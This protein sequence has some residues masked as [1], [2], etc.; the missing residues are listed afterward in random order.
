MSFD[1][2]ADPAAELLHFLERDVAHVGDAEGLVLDLAVAGAEDRVVLGLDDPGYAADAEGGLAVSFKGK[3]ALP[4]R[5]H[6][7]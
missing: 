1:F 5:G 6:A 4:Q 3:H 2:V 7:V